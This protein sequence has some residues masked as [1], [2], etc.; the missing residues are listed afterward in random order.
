MKKVVAILIAAVMMLAGVS[1]FA[2]GT[3]AAEGA[4]Y[5]ALINAGMSRPDYV[6]RHFDSIPAL[7]AEQLAAID[8]YF[9]AI[10]AAVKVAVTNVDRNL[11]GS[12]IITVF[13]NANAIAKI[14]QVSYRISFEYPA[15]FVTD[16]DAPET[17]PDTGKTSWTFDAAEKEEITLNIEDIISYRGQVVTAGILAWF[18]EFVADAEYL[19]V[20]PSDPDADPVDVTN[21][22]PD[23]DVLILPGLAEY[24]LYFDIFCEENGVCVGPNGWLSDVTLT[25]D[26]FTVTGRDGMFAAKSGI[27][28]WFENLQKV[29]KAIAVYKPAAAAPTAVR[30]P[31]TATSY[32]N[33]II[34]GVVL[35]AAAAAAVIG[36]K[37]L[38]FKA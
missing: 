32:G 14:C 38:A 16:T 23:V 37:K 4:V 9:A 2:A 7:T 1:A 36:A 10:D 17:D 33:L 18:D 5:V 26:A 6:V 35:T 11:A 31:D 20:D 25:L 34:L 12:Q 30:L 22:V 8:T 21:L 15:V 24:G 3:P 19:Y 29:I 13:A 28:T 27:R